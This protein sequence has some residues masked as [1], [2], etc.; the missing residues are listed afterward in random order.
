MIVMA[1]KEGYKEIKVRLPMQELE[2]LNAKVAH[3][4]MTREKYI[5][6]LIAERPPIEYPPVDYRLIIR[7]VEERCRTRWSASCKKTRRS[8]SGPK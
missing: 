3:S 4:R 2:V 8:V 1:L 7:R 5:R 6:C